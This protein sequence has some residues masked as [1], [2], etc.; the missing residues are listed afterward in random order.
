MPRWQSVWSSNQSNGHNMDPMIG[1]DSRDEIISKGALI[2]KLWMDLVALDDKLLTPVKNLMALLAYPCDKL[3][4]VDRSGV[5]SSQIRIRSPAADSPTADSPG[6]IPESDPEE[7]PEEDDDEDPKEDPADFL[8]DGGDD[9]DDEDEPSDDDE[10]EEVDIEADDEEEE[11]HPAPADSTTVALPAIDQA[12]SAKETE[13]LSL[14][15]HYHHTLHTALQLGFLFQL[16]YL[17]QFGLMKRLPDFSLYLLHHHHHS[18]H[19]SS[20]LPVLSPSPP[21]SPISPLGYRPVMIRLRAKAASTSHSL[22]LP[23]PIILSH[24]RPD[25]PSSGTPLL[26][27]LSTDRRADIPEVTLPPRK[28]ENQSDLERDILARGCR[29]LRLGTTADEAWGRSM[30]ASDLVRAELMSLR[31]IVLAQQSKIRELQSVDRRRQT[32]IIEML[33]ADHR[34]QEQLAKALKLVKR[35]HTH[36]ADRDLDANMNGRR[37]HISGTGHQKGVVGIDSRIEK[38]ETVFRISNTTELG[39]WKMTDKYCPRTEIKKLEVELTENNEGKQ[40]ITNNPQQHQTRGRTNGRG[41]EYGKC[42]NAIQSKKG[43]TSGQRPTCYE[44]G[45]QEHFKKECPKLKNNNNRG[46]QVGGGNAPAK[47]YAEGH[48]GTNPDFNV[49]MGTFLLNNRY[50]SILFDTGADRSFQ[51]LCV[52][53]RSLLVSPG[54]NETL[55]VYGTRKQWGTRLVCTLSRSTKHR[56]HAKRCYVFWQ[57]LIRRSRKTSQEERLRTYQSSRISNVSLRL[58]ES[59]SDSTSG[60]SNRFDTW[61][62]TRS[63]APYRLAPSEMKEVVGEETKEISGQRVYRPSFLTL[64]VDFGL[65]FVKK[66]TYVSNVH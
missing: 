6:Y 21:T 59:S 5:K 9:G 43:G 61:C 7:D 44:C 27:L 60:I 11:E 24:T 65:E 38:W 34:R 32:G 19:V 51:S 18:P 26:H 46:N 29:D 33:A 3:E 14:W 37:S 56:I 50:A 4:L 36:M 64:V 25:A 62:C 49:V 45:V 30:D 15:P 63:S 40:I 20:P 42:N 28:R 66:R 57:T 2:P 31:T 52:P 23:P 41:L 17:H 10:D 13:L 12:P 22:T 39:E 8:A 1:K 16:Q 35:L 55:I 58:A 47:V 53:R 48:A 54:E